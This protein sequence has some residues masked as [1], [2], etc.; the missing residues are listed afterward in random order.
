MFWWK[1][2]YTRYAYIAVT[3]DGGVSGHRLS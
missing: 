2:N 1:L 3:M